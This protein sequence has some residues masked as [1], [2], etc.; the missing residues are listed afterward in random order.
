MPSR[1]RFSFSMVQVAAHAQ[2]RFSDDALVGSPPKDGDLSTA[3]RKNEVHTL[4]PPTPDLRWKPGQPRAAAKARAKEMR[5]AIEQRG[6]RR[7]AT[8]AVAMASARLAAADSVPDTTSVDAPDT[9][10]VDAA[11]TA[12][13]RSDD[14]DSVQHAPE[15]SLYDKLPADL[16]LVIL[17]MA[18]VAT[19]RALACCASMLRGVATTPSLW[20]A[21]HVQ[22]FGGEPS[23]AIEAP[24]GNG[25]SARA[26]CLE[27]EAL[28]LG[29]RRARLDELPL[30][31]MNDV[32]LAGGRGV[33]VHDGKLL[34][35]WDAS[36]GGRL[37]C[38]RAPR[39]LVCCH[40]SAA[41]ERVAVGD[42]SGFL[43]LEAFAELGDDG[44]AAGWSRVSQRALVAV[45]LLDG[46]GPVALAADESGALFCCANWSLEAA[47][48]AH[49]EGWEELR[50]WPSLGERAGSY[51]LAGWRD[52]AFFHAR[53]AAGEVVGFDAH[54]GEAC[55]RGA[56]ASD[57][58]ALALAALE[59]GG[60]RA[61]RSSRV[62][63][64][65]EEL[66]LV[67]AST[68]AVVSLWDPRTGGGGAAAAARPV[69][70]VAMPDG[71]AATFVGLDRGYGDATRPWHLLASAGA[72]VHVY[73]LRK[74]C[75]AR[76]CSTSRSHVSV[77][78]AAPHVATLSRRGMGACF[79]AEGGSLVVGGGPKGPSALR[80]RSAA[81][82]PA[83]AATDGAD[84]A[85]GAAADKPPAK[86]QR[87]K[88]KRMPSGARG[89]NNNKN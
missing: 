66:S 48:G 14:Q 59:G 51:G 24:K 84:G 81:V 60:A 10:S 57:D 4:P 25:S 32:S 23:S 68:G 40:A 62:A 39:E 31:Q 47:G 22:I 45:R 29:W 89:R 1:D 72:G 30:P 6:E 83:A 2:W 42:A 50:S 19:L 46:R 15:T 79:D 12:P 36:S 67:A 49:R 65:A 73:D 69:A 8:R 21:A 27:S 56:L 86:P 80:W 35:L 5:K 55:W 26:A 58:E 9:T 3:N 53:P 11:A 88:P 52:G 54:A 85:S 77:A 70:Q 87:D 75:C 76:P 43:G 17:S 82:A 44:G 20:E 71:R 74:L 28:L 16:W 78:H 64:Y 34:R 33:S 13:P 61:Q 38:L 41:A 7:E 37:A 18:D 63:S